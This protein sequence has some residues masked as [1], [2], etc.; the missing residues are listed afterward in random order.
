MIPRRP[1][2]CGAG[3]EI[4]FDDGWRLKTA[5]AEQPDPPQLDSLASRIRDHRPGFD[6]WLDPLLPLPRA[7]AAGSREELHEPFPVAAGPT[8]TIT[9]CVPRARTP[10]RRGS[11]RPGWVEQGRGAPCPQV[12]HQ[13]P[14]RELR[15]R[16]GEGKHYRVAGLNLLAAIIHLLEH[17]EALKPGLPPRE[18]RR[19]RGPRP[20]SSAPAARASSRAAPPPRTPSSPPRTGGPPAPRTARW[21]SRR[22]PP[23]GRPARTVS[24]SRERRS[25]HATHDFGSSA[26]W[27][28]RG[29]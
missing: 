25:G 26:P 16:T 17:V 2:R 10:T 21:R 29:R 13:L 15:D 14:R 19:R 23:T 9:R 28:E 7:G 5:A 20:P 11:R 18:E 24:R 8:S 3:E 27:V 12:R 22:P 1:A 4:A 6:P